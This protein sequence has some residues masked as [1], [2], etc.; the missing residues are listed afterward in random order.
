MVAVRG[1]RMEVVRTLIEQ[2]ADLFTRDYVSAGV[3]IQKVLVVAPNLRLQA[4][5]TVA[6]YASRAV[7][8]ADIGELRFRVRSL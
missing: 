4:S 1:G 2:G 8:L 6:W 7:Q 3:H 5:N